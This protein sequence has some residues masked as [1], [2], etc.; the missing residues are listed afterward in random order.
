M[1][2]F[3]FGYGPSL[4]SRM[5]PATTK[6]TGIVPGEGWTGIAGSG[7][8]SVPVDPVRTVGKPAMRLLVPPNQVYTD[9][10]VVGVYAGANNGGTLIDNMG[11]EKVVVHFEG[12]VIDIAEPSLQSFN[13]ANGNAVSYFGWWIE[14]RRDGRNGAAN[15]YFEA[16]PKD[17]ELQRRVMGPYA[18]FPQTEM[19]DYTVT[20][21]PS[22]FEIPGFRYRSITAALVASVKV[23]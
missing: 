8:Q 10:M 22:Q 17:P 12:R 16:V 23:V 2:G 13:D 14:L 1:A 11:L 9:R 6:L 3:G 20:V 15:L 5:R 7:F 21:A 19:H 4:A 18:F